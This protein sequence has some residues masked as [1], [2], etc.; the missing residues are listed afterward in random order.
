MTK[1][2]IIILVR[3]QMGENI[4][5]VARAM[6]N[7]GLRELRIV[8]P[9]D[10]WPNEKAQDMASG[11]IGIVNAAKIFDDFPSAMADIHVAYATTARPRDMEKPTFTPDEAIASLSAEQNT[12]L[13]FGPE[14]TGLENSEIA[15]CD[16]L[17]TIPT[18]PEN[19]SLN[20]GQSMVVL[21]YE[22]FTHT[23]NT[24]A[25]ESTHI[26]ATKSDW[27][28]LFDQLEGYLDEVNYYR[29]AEKKPTMQHNLQ[30]FLMRG[31]WSEQ[32]VRS[33]RG[34]LRSLWEKKH[35]NTP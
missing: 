34:V 8:A 14:R 13:V 19:S 9:R 11:G 21:G 27:T 20:L 35:R 24:P 6:S 3:P 12:A 5:A 29:V 2:P 4:G 28:G 7:F 16:A 23:L 15:M 31:Q 25:K 1:E 32:E 26:P 17:I 10:G 22:W 18:A 30:T 33:F